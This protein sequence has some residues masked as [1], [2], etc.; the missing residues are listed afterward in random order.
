MRVR[1]STMISLP[2]LQKFRQGACMLW[3][4]LTKMLTKMLPDSAKAVL[5][6]QG[7]ATTWYSVCNIRVAPN[8]ICVLPP[9]VR[10]PTR[11]GRRKMIWLMMSWRSTPRGKRNG[12]PKINKLPRWVVGFQR[13]GYLHRRATLLT[14]TGHPMHFLGP[15]LTARVWAGYTFVGAGAGVGVGVRCMPTRMWSMAGV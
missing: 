14:G 9:V 1:Y 11:S 7:P 3:P 15:T 12:Q 13:R 5:A 8:A 4:M 2:W 6:P 10:W